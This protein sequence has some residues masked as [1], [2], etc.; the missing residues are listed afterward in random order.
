MSIALLILMCS[1]TVWFCTEIYNPWRYLV[2]RRFLWPCSKAPRAQD[3]FFE[4]KQAVGLKAD[5]FFQFESPFTRDC[6][7]L[8]EDTFRALWTISS[9]CAFGRFAKAFIASVFCASAKP[10]PRGRS[11]L[12]ILN[13]PVVFYYF[14]AGSEN[15]SKKRALSGSKAKLGVHISR[16]CFKR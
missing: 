5:R 9:C 15:Y 3:G 7:S 13:T 10:K 6:I 12:S 4:H 8:L 1:V 14:L 2:F 11:F 16:A